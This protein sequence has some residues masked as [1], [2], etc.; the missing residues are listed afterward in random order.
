MAFQ[1]FPPYT[2]RMSS[3]A[4]KLLAEALKLPPQ[5]REMILLR[6]RESLEHEAGE[7]DADAAWSEEI[8]RR[9]DAVDDGSAVLHDWDDVKRDIRDFLGR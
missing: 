7:E 1:A 3:E 9:L 6:L 5:Q 8:A 4:E 2:S